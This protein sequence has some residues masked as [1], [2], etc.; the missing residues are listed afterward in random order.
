ML[1]L[2]S[3]YLALLLLSRCARPAPQFDDLL[4][5]HATHCA[6][7]NGVSLATSTQDCLATSVAF[8]GAQLLYNACPP[9]KSKIIGFYACRQCA[10]GNLTLENCPYFV[11]GIPHTDQTGAAECF[12]STQDP[13]LFF[14]FACPT[15]GNQTWVRSGVSTW[16]PGCRECATTRYWCAATGTCF[17]DALPAGAT[18]C[19]AGTVDYADACPSV[20]CA[21]GSYLEGF[22]DTCA[23]C[24]AG[25]ASGG[26]SATECAACDANTFSAPGASACTACAPGTTAANG[27]A[28]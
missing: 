23:P 6:P 5:V 20:S 25:S 21:P 12:V 3:I 10:Q 13:T 16:V 8:G 4:R 22:G 2:K 1:A 17:Y 24:A 19:A 9:G 27:S 26:G 7:G 11:S 18:N 28:A 15:A 14:Q